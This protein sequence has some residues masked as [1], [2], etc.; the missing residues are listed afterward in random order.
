MSAPPV[1]CNAASAVR[2]ARAG[3]VLCAGALLTAVLAL[4]GCDLLAERKSAPVVV[5]DT[6]ETIPDGKAISY[7]VKPG[8]YR[9]EMTATGDGASVQWVG[10]NCLGAKEQTVFDG[11]CELLRDGQLVIGNPTTFGL[12]ADTSVTIK[13]TRLPDGS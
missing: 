9:V 3:T 11:T 12:G 7:P 10:A 4:A 5:L 8:L 2:R 1:P 13:L 6:M